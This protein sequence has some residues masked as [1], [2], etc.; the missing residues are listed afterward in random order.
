MFD[1]PR[2]MTV[3]QAACQILEAIES[4]KKEDDSKELRSM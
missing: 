2:Y 3:A 1:P 4:R